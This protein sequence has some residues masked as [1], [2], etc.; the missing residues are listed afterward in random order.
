MT[1]TDV[2]AG[3]YTFWQVCWELAPVVLPAVAAY[4]AGYWKGRNVE[5]DLHAALIDLTCGGALSLEDE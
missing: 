2:I 5:A 3:R 4:F 1:I